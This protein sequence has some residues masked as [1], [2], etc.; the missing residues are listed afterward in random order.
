MSIEKLLAYGVTPK[1]SYTFAKA[2]DD[3][4]KQSSREPI[5]LG[6]NENP[7]GPSPK[8]AEAICRASA[9][10]N[11]YPDPAGIKLRKRL[12]EIFDLDMKNV[13]LTNGSTYLID[14][15][16]RVFINPGDEIIV[17]EPAYGLYKVKALFNQGVVVPVYLPETD[18]KLD[19]DE[20]YS[21]ITDRTKLIW[22]CTPNNPTSTAVKGAELEAFIKKVPANVIILVDEAY[23]EFAD[24]PEVW[25]MVPLIKEHDNLIVLR[26]FSKMYGLGGLRIGYALASEEI[27]NCINSTAS[28][29]SVSNVAQAAALAALDDSEFFEK[30]Y[31]NNI[32]Q[33][34]Y[35]RSEFEKLG[36]K[37]YESQS[38]FVMV[39]PGIPAQ[40]FGDRLAAE[41]IIV[42]P[43]FR[44]P[45]IT[46]GTPEENQALIEAC[47][48]MAAGQL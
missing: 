10:A 46:V 6:S 30:V 41:G 32:E 20:M 33:K 17:E 5:R 44:F 43:N 3:V 39:D 27:T 4:K 1:L 19:L 42:R 38:N 9:E 36:W 13:S 26:T 24:D 47:R 23:I 31:E 18:Y 48:K 21:K 7:F 40:E 35:L 25:S 28:V 37:M 14:I 29:F 45:R 8:A 12:G 22:I 16:S 2:L 15:L 11:R 34:K